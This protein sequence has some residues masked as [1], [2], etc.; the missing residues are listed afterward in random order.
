MV[1]ELDLTDS[2]RDVEAEIASPEVWQ[3]RAALE[4]RIASDFVEISPS[5][6]I[7]DRTAVVE[8]L[9]GRVPPS[10]RVEDFTVRELASDVALVTYRSVLDSDAG[11]PP[12]ISLRASIW[13]RQDGRWRLT[14][15][16]G[17]AVG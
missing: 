12:A 13:R 10:I 11:D 7:L 14:F 15:H 4:E 16:Q 1:D 17:T 2:I 3:S 9:L 5:G 8:G 6:R